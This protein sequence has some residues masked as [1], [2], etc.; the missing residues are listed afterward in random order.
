MMPHNRFELHRD[1]VPH[2]LWPLFDQM[3]RELDRIRK[4]RRGLEIARA[5]SLLSIGAA[6]ICVW[7]SLARLFEVPIS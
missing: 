1:D 6:A 7:I 4:V 5:W 3:V 2:E